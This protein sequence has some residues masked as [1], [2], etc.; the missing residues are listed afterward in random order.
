[1]NPVAKELWLAALRS[2]EY[3]QGRNVLT[4]KVYGPVRHCCL[5]VLCEV[6]IKSGVNVPAEWDGDI[7]YYGSKDGRGGLPAEVRKWSGLDEYG[8]VPLL[9]VQLTHLNDVRRMS[10]NEIADIIEEQL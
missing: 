1:M 3:S 2:G 4:H 7:K 10:F 9:D 5:G 6:A 8:T